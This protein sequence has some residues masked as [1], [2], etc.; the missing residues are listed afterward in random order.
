MIKLTQQR[1]SR[2]TSGCIRMMMSDGDVIGL[3]R[4][5]HEPSGYAKN[6]GPS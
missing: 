4:L 3:L 1:E 2:L 5:S 6:D